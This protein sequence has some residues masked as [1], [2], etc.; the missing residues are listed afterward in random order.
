MFY[1]NNDYFYL[2]WFSTW[3]PSF[4]LFTN[5]IIHDIVPLYSKHR[6]NNLL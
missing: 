2:V 5:S 1:H 3:A 6:R 4:S